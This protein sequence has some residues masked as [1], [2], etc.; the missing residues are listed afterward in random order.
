MN[1]G[2]KLIDAVLE[3]FRISSLDLFG[4]SRH[5]RI[6][7]ARCAMA[8]L[9]YHKMHM[10][11]TEIAALYGRGNHTSPWAA[12]KRWRHLLPND[13]NALM[14]IADDIW[15]DRPQLTGAMAEQAYAL[16]NKYGSLMPRKRKAAA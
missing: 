7:E 10:T 13:Q 16:W 1:T 9:L 4:T 14:Q 5:P 8:Y 6:V 15:K 2:Q 11:W 12:A 3:Y